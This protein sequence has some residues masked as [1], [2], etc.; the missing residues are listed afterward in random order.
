LTT[1]RYATWGV[2]LTLLLAGCGKPQAL[3]LQHLDPK[4]PAAAGL[5][6]PP[7]PEEPARLTDRPPFGLY[8]E[9]PSS[10]TLAR[11][12]H[13]SLS[14]D[15]RFRSAMTGQGAWVARVDG[16]WLWQITLPSL[17]ATPTAK[18][19]VPGP[20]PATAPPP[21]A[22][23]IAAMEWTPQNTLLLRD[24]TGTYHQAEAEWAKI[25]MLPATLQGKEMLTFSPNGKQ[26]LYYINGKTGKQL[27]LANADG[28]NA[29]FLGENVVGSWDK[30]G[31]P[32]VMKQAA[33]SADAGGARPGEPF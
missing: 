11:L 1:H 23:A 8:A 10:D 14:P 22:P 33:P 2:L 25:T 3:M 17:P 24:A 19:A 29:K 32:A 16:A 13:G 9:Y 4:A 15:G 5:P 12:S 18:P 26:V 27:W 28:T 30:D 7:G 6:T 20:Q 31:K 21:K